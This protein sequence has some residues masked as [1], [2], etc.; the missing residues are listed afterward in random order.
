M[1]IDHIIRPHRRM[2]QQSSKWSWNMKNY[3]DHAFDSAT[4][5]GLSVNRGNYLYVFGP[6]Y[7][8]KA[9]IHA[10]RIMGG[11]AVGMS[12]AAELMEATRLGLPVVGV[13]L[14]TNAAAGITGEALDHNEVKVAASARKEDFALLVSRLII[15]GLGC[16]LFVCEFWSF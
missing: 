13:S 11:D 1:V 7:E 3:A 10:Y 14:I 6:N 9:E 12:T 2:M 8:T 15:G 4:K 5:L 16:R